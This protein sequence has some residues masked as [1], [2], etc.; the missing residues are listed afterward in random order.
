MNY[1]N[2][3][4]HDLLDRQSIQPV[5]SKLSQSRVATAPGT[6]SRSD[7]MDMLLRLAGSDLE[8]AW[9]RYLDSREHALPTGAQELIAQAGTRPDF[10]YASNFAVI[11]IDGPVHQFADRHR[12][13]VEQTE[14]LEDLSYTVIR[15][16]HQDDWAAVIARYPSIFGG[17]RQV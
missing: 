7:H 16:T 13:D 2:Q 14:R 1:M 12:R 9:L 10:I 8:R 6:K 5:L 3:P 11:Y 15:F 17:G 4:D